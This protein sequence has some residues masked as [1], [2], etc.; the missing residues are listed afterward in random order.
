MAKE[1]R[2]LSQFIS[3]L[4]GAENKEDVRVSPCCHLLVL[5]RILDGIHRDL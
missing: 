2:G 3:S 4:R 1:M 5:T